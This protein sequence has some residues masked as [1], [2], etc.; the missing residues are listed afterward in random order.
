MHG[1][2]IKKEPQPLPSRDDLDTSSQALLKTVVDRAKDEFVE[3]GSEWLRKSSFLTAL[4]LLGFLGLLY[5]IVFHH[6]L[7]QIHIHPA[8]WCEG[9][10][11]KVKLVLDDSCDRAKSVLAKDQAFLLNIA[12]FVG[13]AC[14]GYNQAKAYGWVAKVATNSPP[15][16]SADQE[17][18]RKNGHQEGDL[19]QVKDAL[20]TL[21][22]L[23]LKEVSKK[24]VGAE[25]STSTLWDDTF[26]K[27]Q[28]T[29]VLAA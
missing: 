23:M 26:K 1:R 11:A 14:Q 19:E 28:S 5:V 7:I 12:P 25:D 21:C 4:L 8:G 2:S 13:D 15:Q 10:K 9:E 22:K 24:Q 29:A 17:D 18:K 20:S 3:K 27:L 6:H 16:P